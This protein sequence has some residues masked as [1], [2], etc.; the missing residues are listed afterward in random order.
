M[1]EAMTSGGGYLP[2]G[3]V[4]FGVACSAPVSDA[5]SVVVVSPM[6]E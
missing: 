5:A 3:S 1:N 4:F 6:L 2:D